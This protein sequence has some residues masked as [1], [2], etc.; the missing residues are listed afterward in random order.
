MLET[1]TWRTRTLRTHLGDRGLP[2]TVIADAAG[3]TFVVY[4]VS[5]L[6]PDAAQWRRP[7][8]EITGFA[9]HHDAV[10]FSGGDVDFDGHRSDEELARLA[11]IHRYHLNAGGKER[12]GEISWNGIGYHALGALE[13]RLY[14]PRQ[15]VLH[16][17]RAHVSTA[18]ARIPPLA[19]SPSWNRQLIGFCSLGNYADRRD[20]AGKAV[21]PLEDRP[22][23]VALAA[24]DALLRTITTLLG[25]ELTL[26][27]HAYY[28]NKP[29]PGTWAPADSWAGFRYEPAARAVQPPV[30]ASPP[31]PPAPSTA[32]RTHLQ[33][34]REHIAA[35]ELLLP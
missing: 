19:S 35:A 6:F 18:D 22:P 27:P 5:S 30:A 33:I 23:P 26:R 13:D 16:T 9:W 2:S 21:G 15:D 10:A 34:A 32:L 17:H 8:T 25:R 12:P 28:A 24:G 4:D 1:L 7:L 29:C 20:P 3:D 11:V 14:V 31:P